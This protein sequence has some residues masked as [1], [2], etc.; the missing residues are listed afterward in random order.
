MI[1]LGNATVHLMNAPLTAQ[2]V[3]LLVSPANTYLWMKHGV[4]GDVKHQGGDVIE[5][6]ALAKGPISLGDVAIT[7]PG[8]L[9][10]R[11]IAHAAVMA[12][13]LRVSQE[14]IRTA[15]ARLMEVAE[16]NKT[17]S[18]AI[19]PMASGTGS[20]TAEVVAA[21]MFEPMIEFLPDAQHIREVR[22]C[23]PD[24]EYLRLYKDVLGRFFAV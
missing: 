13:D 11:R 1:R 18:L 14:S 24:E 5:R 22:I 19:P 16:E 10:C 17:R 20:P 4:A 3:D 7:G 15:V 23:L 2:D 9:P 12:Q 21:A 8:S 6:E